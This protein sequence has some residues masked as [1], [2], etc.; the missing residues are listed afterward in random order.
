MPWRRFAESNGRKR[1]P[2]GEEGDRE[3][4]DTSF[5]LGSEYLIADKGEYDWF[6]SATTRAPRPLRR[7]RKKRDRTPC[8]DISPLPFLAIV[9]SEANRS[10]RHSPLGVSIKKSRRPRRAFAVSPL[11]CENI[12]GLLSSVLAP[13]PDTE[14]DGP[15][16]NPSPAHTYQRSADPSR[17]NIAAVMNY[18]RWSLDLF[19]FRRGTLAASYT[20]ASCRPYRERAARRRFRDGG[21]GDDGKLHGAFIGVLRASPPRGVPPFLGRDTS[22]EGQGRREGREHRE[23]TSGFGK[24]GRTGPEEEGDGEDP[25]GT[26]SPRE[27]RP[28]REAVDPFGDRCST[29]VPLPR[30]T[31]PAWR[32]PSDTHEEPPDAGPGPG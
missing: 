22:E 27:A 5:L 24:G 19:L 21:P 26:G 4:I 31:S 1:G 17:I 7:R 20:C 11:I 28:V 16:D 14:P 30:A 12:P 18:A 15:V 8:L 32:I 3:R 23:K 25:M 10:A 6:R 13:R 2:R 9:A 29:G